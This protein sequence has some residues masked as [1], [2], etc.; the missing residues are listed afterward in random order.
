MIK[1]S[2]KILAV[3]AIFSSVAFAAPAWE[4]SPKWTCR[5]DFYANCKRDEVCGNGKSSS[6]NMIDFDKMTLTNF[7]YPDEPAT[8]LSKY[9]VEG[10]IPPTPVA[11]HSEN[12]MSFVTTAE[13]QVFA[14]SDKSERGLTDP[15]PWYEAIS[16]TIYTVNATVHFSTCRPTGR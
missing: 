4:L 11:G 16:T 7:S 8:L 10:H 5:G 2:V 15:S 1:T 9:Y 14:I 6:L 3:S 13:G 12:G